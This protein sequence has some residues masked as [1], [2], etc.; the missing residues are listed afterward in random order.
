MVGLPSHL[1]KFGFKVTRQNQKNETI[2]EYKNEMK[3]E[4]P[5]PGK[6]E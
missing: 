3:S 2:A 6:G 5:Q 1:F 4:L